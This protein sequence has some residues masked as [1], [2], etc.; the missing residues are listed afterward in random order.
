M[1]RWMSVGYRRLL[2]SLSIYLPICVGLIRTPPSPPPGLEAPHR[3]S[4]RHVSQ[5]P[6][7]PTA[8]L[9]SKP[10]PLQ[11]PTY[12][13]GQN[14]Q[15]SPIRS[16]SFPPICLSVGR[17]VGPPAALPAVVR[18]VRLPSPVPVKPG[19]KGMIGR[20]DRSFCWSLT[21]GR[22]KKR[23]VESITFLKS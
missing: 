8:L 22:E 20:G 21:R 12:V 18:L 6:Y 14:K 4:T 11:S 7:P 16:V 1:K 15:L 19:D 10:P 2:L 23:A 9:L 17:P 3:L 13:E 5:M